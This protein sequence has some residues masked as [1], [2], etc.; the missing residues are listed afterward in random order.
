VFIGTATEGPMEEP[1]LFLD[2]KIVDAGVPLFH[3]A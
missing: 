1:L 2:S 3:K